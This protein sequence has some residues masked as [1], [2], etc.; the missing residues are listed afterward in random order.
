MFDCFNRRIDYLRISITDRCNLR[1]EYCMP[2]DGIPWIPRERMLS[3]DEIE[4]FT[5]TAVRMG[6]SKIRLTGGEPLVRRNVVDLVA[7]LARLPGVRDFGMTT[8][9]AAL[10]RLAVPLREA[11]LHRINVS[12]DTIDPHRFRQ[13][14]R[15]GNLDDTLAGIE[16]AAAA[17]FQP[18]KLNCVV[19]KSADEP[20]ARGV[21]AFAR[22]HGYPVRFI[23]TMDLAK[24]EFWPVE[25]GEGGKCATCNRLR[26]SC[27]G[28]LYPCLFSDLSYDVR[29][30]GFERALRA[31][32]ENKPRSGHTATRKFATLGG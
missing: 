8:N 23:R 27:D 6:V 2:A 26:L 19:K 3:F 31:T 24:G 11:G 25:G 17:G 1:C 13:L 14:T 29:E 32:L 22:E 21:A 12:L 28:R 7:R 20:D 30:L 4:A 5:R 10:S 18:V 9:G 15:C 16:A